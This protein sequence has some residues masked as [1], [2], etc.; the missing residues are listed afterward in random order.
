LP[1]EAPVA[2]DNVIAAPGKEQ[3]TTENKADNVPQKTPEAV[4]TEGASGDSAGGAASTDDALQSKVAA[5]EKQMAMMQELIALK[6]QQL[7]ALQ[8]QLKRFHWTD[9]TQ[10]VALIVL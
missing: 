8:N 4:D 7:A 10:Q 5:L 2:A 1:G 6:D 9:N 3:I